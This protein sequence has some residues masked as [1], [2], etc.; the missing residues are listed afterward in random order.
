MA[1]R[2]KHGDFGLA[3]DRKARLK[4]TTHKLTAAASTII[5][6]AS[7]SRNLDGALVT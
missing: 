3:P 6:Q 5:D 4:L 1:R 7:A 2:L